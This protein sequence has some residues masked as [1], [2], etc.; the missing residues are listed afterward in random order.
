VL[1]HNEARLQ[2][3]AAAVQTCTASEVV[4][5][6][7]PQQRAEHDDAFGNRVLYF[8]L[9]EPHRQLAVTAISEVEI[10]P[11]VAVGDSPAW[12][13]ALQL[14]VESAVPETRLARQFRLD[15]PGATASPAVRAYAA[16][17]FMPGV[18]CSKRSPISA[19]A[20][21]GNSRSIRRARRSPRRS[22]RCRAAARR[23][24]GLRPPRDRLPARSACRPAT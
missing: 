2:P 16:P 15:S 6:P 17:S 24:P 7:P 12:E 11:P 20:S 9:Q 1:A 19:A 21:I 23:L 22:A 13:T 8:A 10:G 4:I 3:R 18:R 5:D 14:L